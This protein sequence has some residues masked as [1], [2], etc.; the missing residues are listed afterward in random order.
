MW[1]KV[2]FFTP[3]PF[4]K[5][6]HTTVQMHPRHHLR[7]GEGV[8]EG[9]GSDLFDS[10]TSTLSEAQWVPQLAATDV[11]WKIKKN[12]ELT[13]SDCDACNFSPNIVWIIYLL[14]L[15]HMAQLLSR[16]PCTMN[17]AWRTGRRLVWHVLDLMDL[18]WS[19][20]GSAPRCVKAEKW[21]K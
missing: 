2:P 6:V 16:A 3:L 13:V 18:H 9:L 10:P 5:S 17:K 20:H 4:R 11:N 14:K 19:S 15:K 21:K 7:P 1:A 8:E 12:S